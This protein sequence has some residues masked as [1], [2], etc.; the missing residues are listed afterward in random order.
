MFISET[1]PTRK[2]SD[3]VLVINAKEA[4]FVSLD[5]Q[6]IEKTAAL[7]EKHTVIRDGAGLYAVVGTE[8]NKYAAEAPT[9]NLSLV[10]AQ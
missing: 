6:L 9:R 2:I 1:G 7:Q 8:F 3:N 4:S 10:D 5:T